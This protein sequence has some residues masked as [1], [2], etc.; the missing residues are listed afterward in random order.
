MS[1]SQMK[2]TAV[3]MAKIAKGYETRVKDISDAY[4]K[5]HDKNFD[6]HRNII[7]SIIKAEFPDGHLIIAVYDKGLLD[8]PDKMPLLEWEIPPAR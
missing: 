7:N 5:Q 8:Y 6:L 2:K 4:K 1:E 3:H